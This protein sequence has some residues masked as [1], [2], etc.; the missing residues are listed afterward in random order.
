MLTTELSY[1]LH[2]ARPA[3]PT[4]QVDHKLCFYWGYPLAEY[5]RGTKTICDT[6]TLDYP[7]DPTKEQRASHESL[8]DLMLFSETLNRDP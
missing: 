1:A 8:G 4:C 2:C 5:V 3:V 6:L 7:R